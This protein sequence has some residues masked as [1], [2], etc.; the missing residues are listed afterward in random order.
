MDQPSPNPDQEAPSTQI[1]GAAFNQQHELTNGL[2][3]APPP[4]INASMSTNCATCH[5]PNLNW[6]RCHYCAS[7]V[8]ENCQL[9]EKHEIVVGFPTSICPKCAILFKM[10]KIRP[11]EPNYKQLRKQLEGPVKASGPTTGGD[12]DDEAGGV[13]ADED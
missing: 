2:P 13:D 3:F 4:P 7:V 1:Y 9:N 6:A 5:T 8:C 12:D 11:P 10:K